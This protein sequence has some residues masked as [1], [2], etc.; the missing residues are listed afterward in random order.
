M[1]EAVDRFVEEF[2]SSLAARFPGQIEF[3]LLSGSA[4]R[5]D[6]VQGRSD[7]D[8]VVR[9]RPDAD[10]ATIRKEGSAVFWALDRK[11]GLMLREAYAMK[12]SERFPL[13]GGSDDPPF[14]VFSSGKPLRLGLLHPFNNEMLR[15][16]ALHSRQVYGDDVLEAMRARA[17]RFS[18]P[19]RILTYSLLL[20]LLTA[21]LSPVMPGRSLRRCLSAVMF[22]FDDEPLSAPPAPPDLPGTKF[23]KRALSL[24]KD[25]AS[26]SSMAYHSKVAFCIL[27]PFHIMA[28]NLSLAFGRPQA[29]GR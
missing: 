25:P 15:H 2:V 17:A 27:A 9:V 18:V 12:R 5:G 23:A 16:A 19:E 26:C 13:K 21:A 29:N 10:A 11:H 6:F 22:A 28:K 24:K 8:I 4:A 14:V 1:P 7:V 3:V 20:S